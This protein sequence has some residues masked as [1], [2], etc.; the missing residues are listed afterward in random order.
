MSY[1]RRDICAS[2]DTFHDLCIADGVLVI[3]N[4]VPSAPVGL[5]HG[6]IVVD[7][8]GDVWT[9]DSG[10]APAVDLRRNGVPYRRFPGPYGAGFSAVR[11]KAVGCEVYLSGPNV[12]DRTTNE[13][14]EIGRAHV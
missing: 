12:N 8:E 10:D 13:V 2:G 7:G 1:N 5:V 6:R 4:I 3:D 9:V 11:P 14:Y